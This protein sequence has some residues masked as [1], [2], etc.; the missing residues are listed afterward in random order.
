MTTKVNKADRG[1][2]EGGR[3]CLEG[4]L[5]YD[6]NANHTLQTA[7]TCQSLVRKIDIARR[8]RYRFGECDYREVG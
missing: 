3:F 4:W 7:P 5:P 2:V 8:L 1:T 6:R